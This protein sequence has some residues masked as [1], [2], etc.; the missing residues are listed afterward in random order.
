MA[1]PFAVWHQTDTRSVTVLHLVAESTGDV[2]R[3]KEGKGHR[4]PGWG[5]RDVIAKTCT[6]PSAN[7]RAKDAI[8][9][10]PYRPAAMNGRIMRPNTRPHLIA[11]PQ[12]TKDSACINGGIHTQGRFTC[13]DT[14]SGG[15]RG[16]DLGGRP[17]LVETH[18][19]GWPLPRGSGHDHSA[20]ARVCDEASASDAGEG[21]RWAASGRA[22]RGAGGC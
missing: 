13:S 12:P 6:A 19:R 1:T 9:I 15:W 8:R 11:C 5:Q 18:D 16:P 10:S 7:K 20:G 21:A 2:N 17:A 4:S 22:D 14:M 3:S